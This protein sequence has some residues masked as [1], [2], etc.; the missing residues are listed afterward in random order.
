MTFSVTSFPAATAGAITA[1]A[2]SDETSAVA[3]TANW[4]RVTDDASVFIMDGDVGTSGSDLNL[5][6]LTIGAGATVQVTS[7]VINAGNA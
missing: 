4:F 1:S 2:I 6:T 3:G 7:F 5:N